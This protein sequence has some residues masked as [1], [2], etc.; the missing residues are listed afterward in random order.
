[1]RG[2]HGV[3]KQH[4]ADARVACLIMAQSRSASTR[5]K[6]KASRSS[7]SSAGSSR[8]K[9]SSQAGKKRPPAIL[10]GFAAVG[11]GVSGAVGSGVRG[12]GDG[13]REVSPEV[14]RDGLAIM[15]IIGAILIAAREWF[16]LSSWAGTAIHW[17][18]AGVFGVLAVVLP[19]VL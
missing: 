11:R 7:S 8:G 19:V 14:R 1:M 2:I 16:N 5:S 9:N 12:I 6:P 17:L 10:R 4:W 15:L 3:A 13:A 18:V